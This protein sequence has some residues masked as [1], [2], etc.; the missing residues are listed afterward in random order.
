VSRR[1][2]QLIQQFRSRGHVATAEEGERLLRVLMFSLVEFKE[3]RRMMV[4]RETN[5]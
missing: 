1:Q 3:H 2:R 5:A 4:A